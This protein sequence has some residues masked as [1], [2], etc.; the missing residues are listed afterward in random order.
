MKKILVMIL[1]IALLLTCAACSDTGEQNNEIDTPDI[2]IDQ[3]DWSI[4]EGELEGEKYVLFQYTNNSKYTITSLKL[5]FTEKEGVSQEDI[6]SFYAAVQQSQGFGDQFMADY[7]KG[8]ENKDLSI[9]MYAQGDEDIR[10]GKSAEQ[11][12][13]LYLGGFT[14][15]NVIYPQLFAAETATIEYEKGGTTYTIGYDFASGEYSAVEMN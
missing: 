2:T 1:T 3:I 15:K 14:S 7:I 10:P 5:T 11:I 13:C 4:G 12:K 6:D 9:S 8:R